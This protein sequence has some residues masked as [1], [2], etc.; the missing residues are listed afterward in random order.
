MLE[1]AKKENDLEA[2]RLEFLE[3]IDKFNFF[4]KELTI[5]SPALYEI[6]DKHIVQGEGIKKAI[7]ETVD[8]I[9]SERHKAHKEATKFRAAL[10]DP[11][12]EGSKLLIQK[13]K[14][15]KQEQD[16]KAEEEKKRLEEEQKKRHEENCLKEAAALE[17]AGAPQEAIEAVLDFAEDLQPEIFV[18]TQELRSK[19][20]FTPDWKI[21]VIDE[22]AIP[23]EFI[24]RIVNVRAIEKLVK[25]R[26][27]NIKIPG[28][29][30][31]E[32]E[33][34]RRTGGR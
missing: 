29:K 15:Y 14:V 31:I 23:E 20:S 17:D 4:A 24:I 16:R 32:T 6:A 34:T 25:D 30:V 21:E 8:P 19:T 28:I 2:A 7:K 26:K 33:K 13:M 1:I 9:V 5:F 18:P 22:F 27:G 11:I 3:R 10:I 12:E